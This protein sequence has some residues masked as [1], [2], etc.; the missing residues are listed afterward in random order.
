MLVLQTPSR[1]KTF[2][3][4]RDQIASRIH[5]QNFLNKRVID[6][7]QLSSYAH[8]QSLFLT[9]YLSN[10]IAFEVWGKGSHDGVIS[11]DVSTIN[12]A[13]LEVA[14]TYH[15]ECMYVVKSSSM[16]LHSIQDVPV[17]RITSIIQDV[18]LPRSLYVHERSP[19]Q[20]LLKH[21][22]VLQHLDNIIR[23]FQPERA[24]NLS[25]NSSRPNIHIGPWP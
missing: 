12:A 14:V 15:K 20:C 13:H 23:F 16:K 25:L 18:H 7:G 8:T 2:L 3:A 9:T 22:G 5:S 6:H 24:M 17:A 11:M 19:V 21:V 10:L 4:K 1:V